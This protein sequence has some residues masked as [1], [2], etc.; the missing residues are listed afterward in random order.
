MFCLFTVIVAEGKKNY[1]YWKFTMLE[2]QD[3]EYS[4]F[5]LNAALGVPW[6]EDSI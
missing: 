3:W 1:L 6:P 4:A 5:S 2:K